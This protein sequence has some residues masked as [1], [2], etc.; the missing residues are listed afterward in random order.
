VSILR[1]KPTAGGEHLP[2]FTP[3]RTAAE[4]FA[5]LLRSLSKAGTV[6]EDEVLDGISRFYRGSP[7]VRVTTQVEPLVTPDNQVYDPRTGKPPFADL[8]TRGLRHADAKGVL[9][10]L[11]HYG[12]VH[13]DDGGW[14]VTTDE[15]RHAAV[16]EQRR[17]AELRR[18]ITR[19]EELVIIHDANGVPLRVKRKEAPA[20]VEQVRAARL[21]QLPVRN[22]PTLSTRPPAERQ[23]QS[24][25]AGVAYSHSPIARQSKRAP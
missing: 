13:F 23:Q 25:W 18:E 22:W 21:E 3:P 9:D 5:P 19:G 6:S 4:A 14:H 11:A 10:L 17:L 20:I 12:L 2:R 8:D 16:E 15:E 24:S 7:C 1:P